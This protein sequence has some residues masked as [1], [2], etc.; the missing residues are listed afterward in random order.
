VEEGY[1]RTILV[2]EVAKFLHSAATKVICSNGF[3]S[4]RA[5]TKFARVILSSGGQDTIS[6][7]AVEM[8]ARAKMAASGELN[9]IFRYFFWLTESGRVVCFLWQGFLMASSES[10]SESVET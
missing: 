4:P 8:V 1:G 6:E 9:M 3:S 7:M 10:E 5:S 2:H